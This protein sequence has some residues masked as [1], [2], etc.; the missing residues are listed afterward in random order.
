MSSSKHQATNRQAAIR[1]PVDGAPPE[2]RHAAIVPDDSQLVYTGDVNGAQRWVA[3]DQSMVQ[4]RAAKGTLT[5]HAWKRTHFPAYWSMGASVTADGVN[6]DAGIIDSHYYMTVPEG[7][8]CELVKAGESTDRGNNYFDEWQWG[9][10]SQQPARVASLCRVQWNGARFADLVTAGSGCTG[11]KDDQWPPGFPPDWPP[12]PTGIEVSPGYLTMSVKGLGLNDA[13]TTS[14]LNHT[15]SDVPVQVSP[16]ARNYFSWPS[17]PF[18]AP[19]YGGLPITVM[20]EGGDAPGEYR[21]SVRILV[22]T[23]LEFTVPVT[24][25]V[26]STYPPK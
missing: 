16:P 20:F 12:L 19:A 15:G 18:T 17:G 6:Y 25:T 3:M 11:Y 13:A 4:F 9:V 26:T 22:G 5:F 10:N 14:V 23:S 8:G 24:V 21:D 2:V 7:T 1:S